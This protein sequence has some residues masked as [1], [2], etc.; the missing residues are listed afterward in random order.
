MRTGVRALVEVLI[1]AR[2][3]LNIMAFYVSAVATLSLAYT[4]TCRKLNIRELENLEK[5]M[6]FNTEYLCILRIA[7]TTA[8]HCRSRE[9]AARHV[10]HDLPER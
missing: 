6:A 3:C 10:F 1:Q 2:F 7:T 9:R 8:C 5:C 4:D